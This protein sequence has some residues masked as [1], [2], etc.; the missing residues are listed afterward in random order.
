MK[1][2]S[3]NPIIIVSPSPPEGYGFSISHGSLIEVN[4]PH[5]QRITED[6]LKKIELPWNLEIGHNMHDLCTDERKPILVRYYGL[7][8]MA[9]VTINPGDPSVRF[10]FSVD[11][12][13]WI[14]YPLVGS[15]LRLLQDQ[16]RPW[17]L[18]NFGN[19]PSWAPLIGMGEKLGALAEAEVDHGRDSDE[20]QDA[21]AD[22][23]IFAADYCSALEWDL[24]TLWCA[25][26]EMD[27]PPPLPRGLCGNSALMA[28]G[29]LQYHHLKG[30]QGIRGD[31][32]YHKTGGRTAMAYLLRFLCD[33]ACSPSLPKET[34]ERRVLALVY[35]TW[36]KVRERDW[37]AS[38][39]SAAMGEEPEEEEGSAL[40][41]VADRDRKFRVHVSGNEECISEV[42]AGEDAEEICRNDLD[43]LMGNIDSGWYEIEGDDEE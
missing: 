17:V 21:V 12:R 11:P 25:A 8:G 42:A 41:D 39:V 19:R 1:T 27:H 20:F 7:V 10:S 31:A 3:K 28:I 43:C 15:S 35:T 9:T 5:P 14:R 30:F 16:Q 2:P 34:R 38:P 13:G 33:V 6:A 36:A 24:A 18:H 37:K 26:Q 29:S 22:T 32:L 40:T 4:L 23:V